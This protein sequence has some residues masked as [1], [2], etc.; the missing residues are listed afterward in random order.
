MR[1]VLAAPLLDSVLVARY[2]YRPRGSVLCL[3]EDLRRP[4]VAHV[5]HIRDIGPDVVVVLRPLD[6]ERVDNSITNK[7]RDIRL[8]EAVTMIGNDRI[9]R[10]AVSCLI[11]H[12]E[13]WFSA[14]RENALTWRRFWPLLLSQLRPTSVTQRRTSAKSVSRAAASA[15][16]PTPLTFA[17]SSRGIDGASCIR[18]AITD[19]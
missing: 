6:V 17:A 19:E 18:T 15:A 14:C 7:G 8:F 5:R 4:L 2:L 10:G 12:M 1:S 11:G 9:L 13:T 16:A 3:T